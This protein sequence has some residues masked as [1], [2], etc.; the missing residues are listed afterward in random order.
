MRASAGPDLT[1]CMLENK[2]IGN[3]NRPPKS[4]MSVSLVIKKNKQ[5]EELKRRRKRNDLLEEIQSRANGK[6]LMKPDT[7]DSAGL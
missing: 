3:Y 2:V 1:Y 4:V 7:Q 6:C 5:T